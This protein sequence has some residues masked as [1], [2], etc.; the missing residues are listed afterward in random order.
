MKYTKT[1]RA[2]FFVKFFVNFKGSL[3][4]H[5]SDINVAVYHLINRISISILRGTR[6]LSFLLIRFWLFDENGKMTLLNKIDE[7]EFK[8][9]E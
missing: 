6:D 3:Q 4:I 9:K 8:R 5:L 7:I 1:R 2:C